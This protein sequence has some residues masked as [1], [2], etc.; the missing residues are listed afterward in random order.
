MVRESW[1]RDGSSWV[2]R[3]VAKVLTAYGSLTVNFTSLLSCATNLKHDCL[4]L[5]EVF[6][7]I[8]QISESISLIE[9]SPGYVQTS[10][11]TS[12][13]LNLYSNGL[14][15][16]CLILS[17]ISSLKRL[18]KGESAPFLSPMF[19]SLPVNS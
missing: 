3:E 17:T 16:S 11:Y 15:T 14:K 13:S 19:Y 6:F 7:Y 9:I 4:D 18:S 12:N 1:E 10:L 2:V 5:V 8:L